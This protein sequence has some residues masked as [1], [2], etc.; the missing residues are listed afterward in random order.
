MWPLQLERPEGLRRVSV[1]R[2]A[3]TPADA[4]LPLVI[5]LHGAGGSAAWCAEEVGWNPLADRRGFMVAWPEGLP[6]DPHRPAK[7]L[8]NP[9]IWNDGSDWYPPGTPRPD[10]VAFLSA[11]P[12]L[13]AGAFALDRSR[14]LLTG[15][16]NGASMTYLAAESMADRLMGIAPV[17]GLCRLAAPAP[18]RPIRTLTMI[19]S[20]DRLIPVAGG[21]VKNFWGRVEDKPP[22]AA[23]FRHWLGSFGELM[24]FCAAGGSP[25]PNLTS[26]RWTAGGAAG[27][28]TVVAGI[29]HHWP[30]GKGGLGEKL[31][32]PFVT[33]VDACA[34]IADWMGLTGEPR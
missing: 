34:Y 15:F 1:H 30:G 7:F 32:G 16:S 12:D 33:D 24:P 11:L 17:A 9:M 20:E 2:P 25:N 18:V 6:I 5:F 29:G 23:N 3:D 10:D 21:R 28:L 4:E 31:G 13:I 8:T 27:E 14:V 19:G 26:T 22:M